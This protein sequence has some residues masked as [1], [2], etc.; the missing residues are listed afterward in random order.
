ME[1]YHR[2]GNLR[3]EIGD[4]S[5]ED[6]QNEAELTLQDGMHLNYKVQSIYTETKF[7]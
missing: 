7:Q 5:H 1:I 2:T 4:I 3:V 6:I